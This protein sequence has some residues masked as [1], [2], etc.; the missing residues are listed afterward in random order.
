MRSPW[1][2]SHLKFHRA[3]CLGSHAKL[4]I[5]EFAKEQWLALTPEPPPPLCT[6]ADVLA[7]GLSEGP[8]IGEVLRRLDEW[9]TKD[10]VSD[11]DT[12]LSMLREI[13]ESHF[14]GRT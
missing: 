10:D 6:G 12:A 7:L 4:G 8:S 11:R 2:E 3:D 9:V 1:F 5:Y 13:V 14:R